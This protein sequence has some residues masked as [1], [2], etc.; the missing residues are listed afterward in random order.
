MDAWLRVAPSQG[1]D[2]VEDMRPQHRM[3]WASADAL[4]QVGATESVCVCGWLGWE[5]LC[6][7]VAGLAV[8]CCYLLCVVEVHKCS[9]CFWVPTLNSGCPPSTVP[10][11]D[12]QGRPMACPANAAR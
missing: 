3:T 5:W 4:W 10:T 7:E 11:G 2:V 1:L 8:W 9:R 12:D 6:Y